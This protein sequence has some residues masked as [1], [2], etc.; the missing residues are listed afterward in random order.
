MMYTKVH[1]N[2]RAPWWFTNMACIRKPNFFFSLIYF[3]FL[4]LQL[5]QHKK[6]FR[7][8]KGLN[9]V[10]I[11]LHWKWSI[12]I[13]ISLLFFWWKRLLVSSLPPLPFST[14]LLRQPTATT[15][16]PPTLVNLTSTKHQSL[17]KHLM[18]AVLATNWWPPTFTC[19][20]AFVTYH[21]PPG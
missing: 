17:A 16:H 7:Y 1:F 19:C 5:F 10:V 12:E 8:L 18:L 9:M 6:Y 21:W 11:K 3:Y 13:S 20:L 15:T 14:S 4:R 2:G